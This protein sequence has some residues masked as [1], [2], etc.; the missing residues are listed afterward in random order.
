[1]RT[2]ESQ[3]PPHN[4]VS[5]REAFRYWLKLGF[6]N[7]RGPT[8]QIAIMH[9]SLVEEKRWV[10]EERFL[11]ALNYCMLLPGPEAQQLAIYIGWLLHWTIGGIVAGVLFV[12]PSVFILLALSLIY[13]AYGNVPWVTAFFYGLKPAVVAVVAE[14][15]IRIG[16]KTLK[17]ELL[18]TVA[19]LAF[20]AIY[21]FKVPFPLIVLSA[22]LLGFVGG[23][24]APAKFTLKKTTSKS[25]AS[26]QAMQTVIS[27]DAPQQHLVRLSWGRSL[28][29]IL[30]CGVLWFAPIVGLG[31]LRGWDDILVQEGLF[32]SKAAMITFGGA[33]AVLAYL[34]QQAVEHF[35]W[36]KPGQMLDGLGLAE[37][38]PGPLIMVTQWVGFLGAYNHPHGL[39]PFVAGIAGALVTTWST[40]APCFL[41]IFLGAPF[42]E[43]LRGNE[44]LNATLT[45]VTASVVGVILN[46]A[47]FFTQHT[48]FPKGSGPD[49][50]GIVLAAAAFLALT[51]LHWNMPMMIGA[52]GA[53]G[54][55]W[56]ML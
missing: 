47:V 8:G 17:N 43:S 54:L 29:V 39:D 30:V 53:I 25:S 44:R 1:M 50:F 6:I 7:F 38:T 36:I 49:W 48:L 2:T 14:A 40:F 16:R 5:F 24:F 13:V 55:L 19:A 51:R 10:S 21:F 32:F 20:V 23:R 45:A 27:D 42:I 41:W 31:L 46:L 18:V 56:R 35:G 15:V 33:Y 12:L 34:A 11:H 4:T 22:G 28:K 37:S 3:R 9:K 52:A 26:G